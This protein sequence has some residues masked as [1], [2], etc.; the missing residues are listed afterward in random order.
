M[1]EYRAD[2]HVHTALSPCGDD[3]MT[4]PAIVKLAL[5]KGLHIVAICDHNTAGN[6]AAVQKAATRMG[7]D[8]LCVIAG[9]E[10]TTAEEAHVLGLFPDAGAAMAAAALVG[11]TL[12]E[13]DGDYARRFGTQYIID[14]WGTI[15]G[16]EGRM[17]AAATTYDLSGTVRLIHEH[18]GLAIASHIDRPSFSVISQLGMLPPE[19]GFDAVEVSCNFIE[20]ASKLDL[21]TIG[22]PVTQS[23]DAHF[24]WDVGKSVIIARLEGVSFGELAAGIRGSAGREVHRA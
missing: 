15:T 9:M 18:G 22:L 17:L 4:P 5:A 24:L 7:G 2:L 8:R 13:A 23:S 11:A 1:N 16:E 10:I 12:P 14:E 3:A 20:G 21:G 6:V 19:A